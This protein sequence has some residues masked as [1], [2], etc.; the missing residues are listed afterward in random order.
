M[1]VVLGGRKA[2]A[3]PLSYGEGTST[4]SLQ[5]SA[6]LREDGGREGLGK[7]RLGLQHSADEVPA[8]L[9]CDLLGVSGPHLPSKGI[10]ET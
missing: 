3:G 7:R 8:S 6:G 2:M 5:L 9:I 4:S 10:W 1:R